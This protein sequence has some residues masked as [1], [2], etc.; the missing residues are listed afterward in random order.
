MSSPANICQTNSCSATEQCAPSYLLERFRFVFGRYMLSTQSNPSTVLHTF[1]LCWYRNW[2]VFRTNTKSTTN[3]KP[4]DMTLL[5]CCP[6]D[7]V[8]RLV[9]PSYTALSE[10]K[11]CKSRSCSWYAMTCM[12]SDFFFPI[13]TIPYVIFNLALLTLNVILFACFVY[14]ST[15]NSKTHF[16]LKLINGTP[17]RDQRAAYDCLVFTKRSESPRAKHVECGQAVDR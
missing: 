17:N 2:K 15:D 3:A 13:S 1:W 5:L 14:H 4:A 16:Q 6:I 7:F 8:Q 11:A 12:C 9:R 10:W